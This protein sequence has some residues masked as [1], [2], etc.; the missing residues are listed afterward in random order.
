M[1]TRVIKFIISAFLISIFIVS[2]AGNAEEVKII[3][4]DST[5][6]NSFNDIRVLNISTQK[7]ADRKENNI[8]T[9]S[10]KPEDEIS[11]SGKAYMES[12]FKVNNLSTE[13]NVFLIAK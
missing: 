9:I 3:L 6:R 4:I 11:I 13:Y 8:Y 10:A 7:T 2:C 12:M 5:S 1:E